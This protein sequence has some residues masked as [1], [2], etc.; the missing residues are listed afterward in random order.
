VAPWTAQAAM[1]H[2]SLDLTMD[3]Y[4][5]PTLLDVA[6]ALDV[7]PEL[8]LD[9]SAESPL[10]TQG[11]AAEKPGDESTQGLTPAIAHVKLTAGPQPGGTVLPQVARDVS[12][13]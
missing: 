9:G 7:L 4:T 8:S 3:V 5:D 2:S 6:G 10:T 13:R 12:F 11:Q 1:R